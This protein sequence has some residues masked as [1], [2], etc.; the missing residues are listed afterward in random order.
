MNPIHPGRYTARPSEPLALFL[1]GM[2]IHKPLRI[3][4]WWP[5]FTAM[6]RMLRQLQSDPDLG[7]LAATLSYTPHPLLVQYWQSAKHVERFARDPN[8]S[9]RP[10]WKA[11]NRLSKHESEVMGLWHE[12]YVIEPATTR[13]LYRNMPR[14]GLAAATDHIPVAPPIA[15]RRVPAHRAGSHRQP[16]PRHG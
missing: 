3:R 12:L 16:M 8:L 1:V 5:A 6:S 10:A 15:D 7:L 2:R 9:H 13:S 11:F 14:I 4:T